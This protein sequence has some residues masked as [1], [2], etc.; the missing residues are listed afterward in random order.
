MRRKLSEFFVKNVGGGPGTTNHNLLSNRNDDDMFLHITLTEKNKYDGYDSKINSLI[1]EVELL[2]GNP[3]FPEET[4]E[5]TGVEETGVEETGVEETGVE[6]TGV[7]ETGVEETSVEETSVEETGVEETGLF[8]WEIEFGIPTGDRYRLLDQVPSISTLLN[9][10][11]YQT[12]GQFDPEL[13]AQG[14]YGN[15]WDGI[16]CKVEFY[17][18]GNLS[19]DTPGYIPLGEGVHSW[20]GTCPGGKIIYD[21][22]TGTYGLYGRFALQA[23][24]IGNKIIKLRKRYVPVTRTGPNENDIVA[25]QGNPLE[26]ETLD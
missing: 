23:N 22:Y 10:S 2:G 9:D 17:Y 20:D 12:D 26:D 1:S 15:N 8:E 7:E 25:K 24:T 6:E 19:S 3:T 13:F 21:W 14:I 18:T 16:D 4:S 5:E 11:E